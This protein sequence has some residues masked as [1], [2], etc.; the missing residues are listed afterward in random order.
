MEE[1]EVELGVEWPAESV[2][3]EIHTIYPSNTNKTVKANKAQLVQVEADVIKKTSNFLSSTRQK[4]GNMEL[5]KV[6]AEPVTILAVACFRWDQL[7]QMESQTHFLSCPV[8][9]TPLHS[10]SLDVKYKIPKYRMRNSKC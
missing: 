7:I 5:L 9:C 8:S 2:P 6:A 1:L 4:Q 10:A 3:Q